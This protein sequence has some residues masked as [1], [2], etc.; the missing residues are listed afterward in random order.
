MKFEIKKIKTN[1]CN[2]MMLNVAPT[3]HKVNNVKQIK[4]TL[5]QI[6]GNRKGV[7]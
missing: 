7:Y 5:S 3:L 6:S 4:M 2:T 1:K